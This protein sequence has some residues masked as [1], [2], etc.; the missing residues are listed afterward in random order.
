MNVSPKFDIGNPTLKSLWVDPLN[1]DDAASGQSRAQ[2][3]KTIDAAWRLI[4]ERLSGH[5]WQILLCP[6]RYEP[7][8]TGQ[9]LLE[10]RHGTAECPIII[11]TADAPLSAELPQT[12]FR[13]CDRIYMF[14]L[15]LTAPGIS[16]VIPSEN[17]VLHYASCNDVLIRGVTAIG[18]G[19]LNGLPLLTMKAN[20]CLRVYI[21]DCDFSG[22]AGNAIDLVVVQY[23]HVVRNRLH[24]TKGECMYVK[25]GA[26]Y[27]LIAENEMYDGKNVGIQAGQGTGFQYMVPPWLHYEAYDIKIVNNIIHDAGAGI[28]VV[29]GY[30]I[31]AAYNTCYRVGASRDTI[32]IGL[33]GRGWNGPRP[34][35]IDE[36]LRLGGWCQPQGGEGY[37]IPNRNV[38]ICNNV[39]YNPDGYESRHAH[40]GFSGPVKTPEGSNLP[41]IARA[42]ENLILSGNLIWNGS[43]DKPL[44]DDCENVYHLAARPTVDAAVLLKLNAINTIRPELA[45]PARGDFR[46]IPGGNLKQLRPVEIDDFNWNDAPTQPS[47]PPGNP[48]NQVP[49]DR[50]GRSRNEENNCIGAFTF[51]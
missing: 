38:R 33:G 30:N 24:N 29:G 10:D 16:S 26:A 22:A 48:D 34:A 39:I 49:T 42:D 36:Y 3:V 21:E 32:I 46:P 31:L 2:A 41:P 13:R 28:G 9:V 6:G 19:G 35:I 37:N 23:G 45:D 43:R 5:G 15:K 50:A 12:S 20:Q 8:P 1:G 25:G 51:S 44:L 11:R 17:I 40:I 4:P 18:E 14:D 47:V 27:F 7:G